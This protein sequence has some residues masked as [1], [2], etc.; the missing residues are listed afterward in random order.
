VA[1]CRQKRRARFTT[2]ANLVN[3]LVEAR[4][5]NAVKRALARCARRGTSL[6]PLAA[7]SVSGAC[8]QMLGE[9]AAVVSLTACP[10]RATTR[11]VSR[12]RRVFGRGRVR[13]VTG[14]RSNRLVCRPIPGLG[15]QVFRNC[16]GTR[17]ILSGPTQLTHSL[18][19]SHAGCF[20]SLQCLSI[21]SEGRSKLQRPKVLHPTSPQAG[22]KMTIVP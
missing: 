8:L 13:S 14:Q 21:T 22:P 20:Q 2:A 17:L 19:L 7:R 4:Q 1:A 3:E 9:K 6:A 10:R 16:Y 5:H 12:S 11:H 15:Q 18:I